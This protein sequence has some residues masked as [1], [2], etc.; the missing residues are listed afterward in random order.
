VIQIP[1]IRTLALSREERQELE[2]IRDTH[3]KA[4]MRE[5]ASAMLKIASGQVPYQV[6]L[7]GLLKPRD[8]DT[9]YTW[10]DRYEAAGVAG[11]KNK[12]GRGRKPAFSPGIAA[13]QEAKVALLHV[14]R[15]EPA[16]FGYLRSRWS[17]ALLRQQLDWLKLQTDSGLSQLLRRL[18]ISY[19][20]GRDY[21]HS[22]DL[23]Y[24]S[25][26]SLIELARLRAWYAPEAYALLY[27]DEL[28]YYR[29][30]SLAYAYEAAGLD[31]PLAYRSHR[32][33]TA[34]RVVAALDAISGRVLYAQRSHITRQDLSAFLA[35]LRAAYPQQRQLDLVVDNW[36]VHFHPDV[37]A[38]LQP[39]Q[40]PYPPQLPSNW[41][42]EPSPRAIH[43]HLPIRLRCL[44]TYASWLNPIEKL[45]RWLKQDVLH[46]HRLA[47]HWSELKLRVADFLD[48]FQDGS[49]D[50]LHYVGLLPN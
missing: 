21:V 30:P 14:I 25:K 40:F 19:K 17:L 28:T 27:L 35:Q 41:P 48:Q 6:A 13:D 23:A 16:C 22:P 20:R 39:Q 1:K 42:T 33:N 12:P 5:R 8:P 49:P 29:Q 38:R 36:P 18:G 11:L 4:Y 34:F 44:P 31:Q 37:L 9:V 10:L 32:S 43:D 3:S 50:L 15:R 7:T 24:G 46:L 45:W 26:L 47:D 2:K